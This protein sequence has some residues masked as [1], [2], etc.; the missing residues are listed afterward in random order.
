MIFKSDSEVE[1]RWSAP[2]FIDLEIANA[3]RVSFGKQ[4]IT[5]DESDEK[6]IKYLAREKHMSPFRHPQFSFRIKTP[7]FV[8]RQFYKHVIGCNYTS[9][10]STTIDHAWNEISGRYVVLDDTFYLPSQWR[11]Q[12]KSNKQASNG[13]IE[14]QQLAEF[15][16]LQSIRKAFANYKELIELG[17]AK[18]QARTLIPLS[19]YTEFIWTA[20]LE[21]IVNFIKLRDHEGAQKEIRDLAL[22]MQKIVLQKAPV[23]CNALLNK[24]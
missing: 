18:E 13:Y 4:K 14:K 2:N 7:E 17:V 16:Y 23:A 6:L 3:A 8:A 9:Q 24:E 10:D 21:A 5:F 20:S 1:L 15:Y 12:S 22:D 19:F 11:A